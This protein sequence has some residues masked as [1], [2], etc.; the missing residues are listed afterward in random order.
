MYG[1]ELLKQM[2]EKITETLKNPGILLF[3]LA[4]TFVCFFWMKKNNRKAKPKERSRERDEE[5]RTVM[6]EAGDSEEEQT[7]LGNESREEQ[8]SSQVLKPTAKKGKIALRGA[9]VNDRG[10]IRKNNEDNFYF[11]G[12]YLH[13]K[14]RNEGACFSGTCRKLFQLYAV[15]DGMGGEA[16]GEE[17]SFTAVK[18][19][20]AWKKSHSRS[21]DPETVVSILQKIS[22]KIHR[23]A[24]EKKR[25]SG[26]TIAMLLVNHG[27]AVLANVGDSRVYRFRDGQ[28]VQISVDHTRVRKLVAMGLMT[29][30]EARASSARHAITQYLGMSSSAGFFPYMI[31]DLELREKDMYLLCS[32]G[33]TDMV[34]DSRMEAVLRENEEP[35]KAAGE[36]LKAALDGGGRDNVTIL[37]LYVSEI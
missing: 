8:D 15:C 14:E 24:A 10:L 27:R 37:L 32:D 35:E 29:P 3:I 33:L 19:L 20:S 36:L 17:A 31:S 26:T 25:K 5:N 6:L 7:Y 28:L 18:E 34:E 12:K 9:V 21:K 30:E 1:S 22:E 11:N 16:A 2:G 23:E 13:L 4:V